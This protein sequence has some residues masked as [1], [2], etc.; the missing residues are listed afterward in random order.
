MKQMNANP[1]IELITLAKYK[2]SNYESLLDG[3]LNRFT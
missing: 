1:L 3:S 2:S